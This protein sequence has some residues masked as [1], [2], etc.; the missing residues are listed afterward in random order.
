[1]SGRVSG[2]ARV[3][4]RQASQRSKIK[5]RREEVWSR[6]RRVRHHA[7]ALTISV[8]A[9]AHFWALSVL[10]TSA[11]PARAERLALESE[12]P[13]RYEIRAE[14]RTYLEL[15]QRALL[16]GPGGMLVVT[17]TLAP[18]HEYVG[19]RVYGL[20]LPNRR[21][22]LDVELSGWA[23]YDLADIDRADRLD[24]DLT[25]ANI[26]LDFD[27]LGLKAGRQLAA[28][29]AAGYSRFDGVSVALELGHGLGLQTYAGLVVIQPAARRR[30]Y[31]LLGSAADSLRTN[32]FF[33]EESRAGSWLAGARLNYRLG[34]RFGGAL[35]YHHQQRGG[36][37]DRSRLAAEANAGLGTLVECAGRAAF[38]VD[39]RALAD[40]RVFCDLSPEP[41]LDLTAE[42]LH[43]EPALLLS[44]QSVLGVF[45]TDGF[46]ELGG[47]AVHR[48]LPGLVLEGSAYLARHGGGELGSRSGLSAKLRP[49]GTDRLLVSLGYSRVIALQNGYHALRAALRRRLW[50]SLT[51]TLEG[52]FYSYDQAIRGSQNSIVCASTLHSELGS[53]FGVL[54]GGSVTSSPYARLDAQTLLRVSY[55]L[56]KVEK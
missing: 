56:A 36:E 43:T 53:G 29:G 16:P 19:L 39:A 52:Y 37:L 7:A 49:E 27:W 46:D 22:A 9:R 34:S 30:G 31:F 4:S 41:S 40:A 54:L 12:G 1:M 2:I 42:A 18:I 17:D 33:E 23:R 3:D 55:D 14:S 20:D 35:A 10:F 5:V 48:L 38:E 26:R 15:Y 24:G 6:V 11:L 21:D 47:R 45:S 8:H 32:L 50:Q 44:R 28:G 25:S 13:D 51:G